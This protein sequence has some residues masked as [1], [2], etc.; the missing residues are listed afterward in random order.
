MPRRIAASVLLVTAF[1]SSCKRSADQDSRPAGGQNDEPELVATTPSDFVEHI[2]GDTGVTLRA[3]KAWRAAPCRG[4][5]KLNLIADELGRSVN[6]VVVPSPESWTLERTVQ[7]A[8]TGLAGQFP[9]FKLHKA[10]IIRLGGQRAARIVYEAVPNDLKLRFCQL[11][12][13]KN[14]KQHILTY[15]ARFDDFDELLPTFEQ[16]A[17]SVRVP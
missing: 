10:D 8:D 13:L 9:G 1:V 16:V 4:N 12:I 17:V 15:T 7:T 5:T 3:P 6:L 14:D 2:A 11:F